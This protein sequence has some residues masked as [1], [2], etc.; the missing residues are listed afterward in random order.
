MAQKCL[1]KVSQREKMLQ[2]R[3]ALLKEE[4]EI[5]R[6]HKAMHEGNFLSSWLR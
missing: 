3:G 6:E 2:D 1:W 4:G 5:V